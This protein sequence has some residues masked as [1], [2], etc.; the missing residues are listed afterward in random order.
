ME[1]FHYKYES[2]LGP[3]VWHL[4]LS[5]RIQKWRSCLHVIILMPNSWA[6]WWKRNPRK[7]KTQLSRLDPIVYH[8]LYYFYFLILVVGWEPLQKMWKQGEWKGCIL[9]LFFTFVFHEYFLWL[10]IVALLIER[11]LALWKVFHKV[12]QGFFIMATIRTIIFFVK[13]FTHC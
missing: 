3:L 7:M 10:I 8:Y 11:K 13:W 2:T 1:H 12:F 4:S 5:P 6:S 9:F